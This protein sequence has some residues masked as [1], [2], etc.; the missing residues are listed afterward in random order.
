MFQVSRR[1]D[2]AVRIMVALGSN[3]QGKSMTANEIC[4]KTDVPKPFL[5][6]ISA[7]LIRA[8]LMNSQAGPAGGLSLARSAVAINLRHI[9]EA[10]EGP[11]CINICL[12]RPHE[13][14][15]DRLCPA[16]GF[17]GQLQQSI[18][19]QLEAVSVADLVAE[20]RRLQKE[21]RE[22]VIPYLYPN[23]IHS[24]GVQA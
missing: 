3:A 4:R 12:V 10:V 9:V 5:H 18:A 19:D 6:K 7:D 23:L 16:H 15:R 22:G 24:Q 2:Y 11:L 17:W 1:A 13:C 14:P 8:G 20:G 21:P